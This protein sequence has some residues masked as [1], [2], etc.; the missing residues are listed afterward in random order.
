MS[1]SGISELK[2]SWV[3]GLEVIVLRTFCSVKEAS[4]FTK[5]R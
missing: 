4:E 1:V 2:N 5:V 3:E